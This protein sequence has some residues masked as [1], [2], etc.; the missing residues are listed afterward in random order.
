MDPIH[1]I[2]PQ[3]PTLPPVTPSP[4]AEVVNR[5]GARSGAERERRRRPARDPAAQTDIEGLVA[6]GDDDSD[7]PDEPRRRIDIT[8]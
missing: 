3:S 1:P 7:E 5:D 2:I 4:R 8:A 6:G